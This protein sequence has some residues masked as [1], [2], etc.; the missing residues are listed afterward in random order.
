[1]YKVTEKIMYSKSIQPA[2]TYNQQKELK[3]TF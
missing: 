3:K 2:R 1:M